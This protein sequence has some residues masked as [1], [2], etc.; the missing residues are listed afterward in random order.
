[1]ER[2][3]LLEQL[4]LLDRTKV[5][6][7][8]LLNYCGWVDDLPAKQI[9]DLAVYF[10]AY[11]APAGTAVLREGEKTNFFAVICEGSVDVI[12]ESSAGRLKHLKTLNL[13]KA[14]GEMAFFD[15]SPS[16]TTVVIREKA[17]LLVMDE[18][19]FLSL[20]NRSPYIALNITIKLIKTLSQRLRE[21]SGKLIDHL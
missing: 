2:L 5:S 6:L 1:M 15:H 14:I 13:G 7:E 21:T 18:I 19:N 9:T 3:S 10:Q 20:C 8:Q 16:S 12:K 17:L 4:E 11:S